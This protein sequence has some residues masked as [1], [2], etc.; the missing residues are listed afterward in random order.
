MAMYKCYNC[1]SWC[2]DDWNPMC[3]H[4]YRKRLPR[5]G[6]PGHEVCSDCEIELEYEL[7]EALK[8]DREG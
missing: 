5:Y 8:E 7:E 3:E 1:D 2:D 6:K 4:P